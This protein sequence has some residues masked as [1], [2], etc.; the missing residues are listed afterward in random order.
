MVAGQEKKG[1]RAEHGKRVDP[2]Q[3]QFGGRQPL[4]ETVLELIGDKDFRDAVV[5]QGVAGSGKSSSTLRLAWELVR[6]G[7]RPIRIELKHLQMDRSIEDALP[8]AVWLTDDKRSP[9]VAKV[10]FGRDLFLRDDIFNESVLFRGATICPYVLILDGW[11]E[12]SIGAAGSFRQKVEDVLRAVRY[13][14]L[15][16]RGFPV[17]VVLAGRPTEAIE[18]SNFLVSETSVFSR[19]V[20]FRLNQLE[21]FVWKV[22]R[23]PVRL[24]NKLPRTGV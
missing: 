13:K 16:G 5:I 12:L 1:E 4:I 24:R 9:L 14:F 22:K 15:S 7:L 6:Q 23:L 2:F 18:K 3:E 17:R 21:I 8:E 19:C 11:D 20:I 10:N